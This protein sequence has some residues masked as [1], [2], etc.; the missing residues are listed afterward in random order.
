MNNRIKQVAE[1]LSLFVL[2]D[3]YYQ[4]NTKKYQRRFKIKLNTERNSNLNV[5]Y[6]KIIFKSLLLFIAACMMLLFNTVLANADSSINSSTAKIKKTHK[7]AEVT[8]QQILTKTKKALREMNKILTAKK[9]FKST[10]TAAVLNRKGMKQAQDTGGGA[11]QALQLLPGVRVSS[12]GGNSGLARDEIAIR[13]IKVGWSSVAGDLE[14]N[15]IQMLFDGIPVTNLSGASG[16]FDSNEYPIDQFFS[17]MNVIYG[18][19]NPASRW[20]NS[21][22]G[23]VN[24]IPI[25][26]TIRPFNETNFSFG[27]FDTYT[28]DDEMSTGMHDGWDGVAAAGYTHADT[29][30]TGPFNAPGYG[31]AFFGKL[32]KIF[33]GNSFSLGAYASRT[34]E[35][36]PNF[37]PVS[38]ISGITTEGLDANAPLYSEQT[39]G[40][41][42]SL[43]YNMWYKL[44]LTQTT[45]LYSKLNINLTKNLG[46][47]TLVWYRHG[48]REHDR[49]DNYFLTAGEASYY[50]MWQP[51][52]NTYGE[53]IYSNYKILNNNL[54][55][56]EYDIYGRL[57]YNYSPYTNTAPTSYTTYYNNYLSIFAQDKIKLLKNLIIEPGLDYVGFDTSDFT[58][59]TYY[60]SAAPPVIAHI[61]QLEPSIG[62]NYHVLH[63]LSL[64]GTWAI[65]YQAPT[66]SAYGYS[67]TVNVA[68]TAPIRNTDTEAGFKVMIKKDKYLHHFV[69]N[70]NYFQN[71]LSNE[72]IY[73]YQPFPTPHTLASNGSAFYKG[74]QISAA[75]DPYT[76]LH[77]YANYTYQSANYKNFYSTVNL[78]Q[79][80]NYPVSNIPNSI[81]NIGAYYTIPEN[82]TIYDIK[83]WDMYTGSQYMFSNVYAGPTRQKMP[84]YNIV[85]FSIN[86]KTVNFDKMVPGLRSVQLSASVYNLLNK[87]FNSNEYF[88]SGSYFGAGAGAVLANPGAPRMF[89]LS[90][91]MKF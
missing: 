82:T 52:S 17:G 2:G 9:I 21:L 12:Y 39:S 69:F 37:I 50:E 48:F 67:S 61:Y 87:K 54:K 68:D 31:Y 8:S 77:L 40:Y 38:P 71:I 32:I 3:G 28:L 47:H 85:N 11:V 5:N 41:Y 78:Q 13:G 66:A 80:P 90:A 51:N 76:N 56:G 59:E 18:P 91:T 72:T 65:S 64:Y 29:F 16:G 74:V 23:T 75:E 4:D 86:V 26:P 20:Y 73:I 10:Q 6:Y 7:I 70:A 33:N 79:Y 57:N 58:N 53:K 15:G 83:L 81:Y 27:S 84:S 62:I 35:Y 22:G 34:H 43:P 14:K 45:M 1:Y 42:S 55:F 19:G 88:S 25:Q 63:N 49:V 89:F 24:M 60:Q 46:L 44:L 30:R 36:R